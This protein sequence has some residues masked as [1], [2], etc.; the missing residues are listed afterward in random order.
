MQRRD[1]SGDP[2]C[3]NG[4]G[5]FFGQ[6]GGQCKCIVYSHQGERVIIT[7]PHFTARP[8]N[9]IHL[10]VP[11]PALEGTTYFKT[12]N[13]NLF[14]LFFLV[15]SSKITKKPKRPKSNE[16][17]IYYSIVNHI[18]TTYN[19]LSWNGIPQLCE[20]GMIVRLQLVGGFPLPSH[21]CHFQV[22]SKCV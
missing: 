11:Q 4:L 7:R 10:F 5:Y 3:L 1:Q 20:S 8:A 14:F 12:I 19:Y 15:P 13:S 17:T 6:R 22:C 2:D 16:E 21:N 18:P 9:P